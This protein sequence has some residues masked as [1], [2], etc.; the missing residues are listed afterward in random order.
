METT[1]TNQAVA[2]ASAMERS[3]DGHRKQKLQ[4]N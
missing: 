1:E 3:Q 4:N 2:I